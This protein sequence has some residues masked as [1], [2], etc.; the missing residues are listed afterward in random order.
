MSHPLVAIQVGSISFVDEGVDAVLDCFQEKGAVNALYL[1]NFTHTRGTGGRQVPGHPLPDHGAQ[2]YD[3]DW[4][5]GNYGPGRP[6]YYRRTLVDPAA[7]AAPEHPGFPFLEEVVPKAKAR[8]MKVY[9]WMEESSYGPQVRRIPGFHHCLE[10][11]AVGRKTGLPCF[12]NPDYR[13]WHFGMIE[14]VIQA[15]PVDGV[16]WCSERNG[17]LQNVLMKWG[18]GAA[19]TCF[20]EHC[21]AAGREQGIDVARARAGMLALEELAAATERPRDGWFVTFWRL[22]LR[23]PEILAWENLWHESQNQLFKEMYG[24]IKA[25]NPEVRFGWHI[26]HLNSFSPFYRATQDI[27]AFTRYADFIKLVAYNNC[28]GPRFHDHLQY[29]HKL[30]FADSTAERTYRLVYD[31][32]GI[33]E[34]PLEE[35]TAKGWSADYVRRETERALAAVREA[36]GQTEIHPGIDVD[37][38]TGPGKKQTQPEDVFAAV[39]A[40][41][42]AG[43]QGVV[44][45]RKYSEMRL[46]NLAAA[47]D[48]VRRWQAG[49]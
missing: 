23:Y 39:T 45:S 18:A 35:I 7:A 36:G 9:C 1:A 13:H 33:D 4:I 22:L 25:I 2:D 27:A 16:A 40:A 26:M 19:L 43:A 15:Y 29:L 42:E 3:H 48:A 24:L 32:L 21:R 8:E 41:L 46:A 10:I 14:D 6:E 30:F 28:A 11:D 37:I 49:S 31:L 47:G 38:P 17:P 44:L 20:C 34:G 5:G 12:N